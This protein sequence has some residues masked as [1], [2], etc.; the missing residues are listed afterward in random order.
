MPV[1]VRFSFAI[2]SH[3]DRE[4]L[5]DRSAKLGA[6]FTLDLERDDELVQRATA[7]MS[8]GGFSAAVAYPAGAAPKASHVSLLSPC[9]AYLHYVFLQGLGKGKQGFGKGKSKGLPKGAGKVA[10][11]SSDKG[12]KRKATSDPYGG[13]KEKVCA[14]CICFTIVI[15]AAFCIARLCDATIAMRKDTLQRSARTSDCGETFRSRN[16]FYAHFIGYGLLAAVLLWRQ[17][18]TI[19]SRDFLNM[20]TGRTSRQ[21]VFA[22][23]RRLCSVHRHISLLLPRRK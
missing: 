22:Y 7:S 2:R 20:R 3:I 4:K 10:F 21:Q 8:R 11:K 5:E 17:A 12:S 15:F 19:P 6:F 14:L 13:K 23:A 9:F 1:G 16:H 18:L